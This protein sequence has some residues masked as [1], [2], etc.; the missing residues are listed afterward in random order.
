MEARKHYSH[1]PITEAVI[2]I[3]AQLSPKVKLDVLWQMYSNIQTEYPKCEDV[4]ILQ[5]QMIV[6]ATVES[7]ATQSQIGYRVLSS[8]QKHIIEMRLDGF[9]FSRLA[10]YDCW[11]NFRDEAQRLWSIYQ[12]LTYPQ[13]ITR[14]AIRYINR[15]DIP[16]PVGD[17][18]EYLRTFPEVSGNLPQGLSGYFM[19]LQIPQDNLG[20]MLVINQAIVTPPTEEVV[21]ILLDLDLFVEQNIANNELGIWE[22]L[23]QMHTQNNQAFEACITERTRELIN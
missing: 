18:Q 3:Q 20:A 11:E 8:D 5:G 6:A 2:N 15:L 13:A 10:P 4:F 23:E 9:S 22:L 17:L 7:T 14:L 1:A 12:S 16:L 19:Q 21:S